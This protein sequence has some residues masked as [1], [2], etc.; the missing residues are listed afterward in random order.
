MAL[1]KRFVFSSAALLASIG[2]SLVAIVSAYMWRPAQEGTTVAAEVAQGR[3]AGVQVVAAEGDRQINLSSAQK[4]G[5]TS[6]D[7]L[8]SKTITGGSRESHH[9]S[10]KEIQGA[11]A[12]NPK[13]AKIKAIEAHFAADSFTADQGGLVKI[14][15]AHV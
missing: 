10:W 12:F 7:W 13:A 15:R 3:V 11:I 6:V 5:N 2:L 8:C 4:G 14:G 1:N 9:G